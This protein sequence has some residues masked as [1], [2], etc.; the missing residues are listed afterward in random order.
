MV[1]L[2]FGGRHLVFIDNCIGMEGICWRRPV[3]LRASA[4]RR[5]R[6]GHGFFVGFVRGLGLVL[7]LAE[8]VLG[9]FWMSVHVSFDMYGLFGW[10]GFGSAGVLALCSV[11]AFALAVRL[12]D[13]AQ[14]FVLDEPESLILAQSERWRHA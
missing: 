7:D 4:M 3:V 12:H 9:L 5:W 13:G 6:F 11:D 8:L 14:C 10:L 2:P 1:V